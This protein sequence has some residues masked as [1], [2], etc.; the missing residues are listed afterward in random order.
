M[1]D[2][3][4]LRDYLKRATADLSRTKRLLRD[5]EARQ[6]EPIAIVAMSCRY[7][8]GVSSPEDLWELVASGGDAVSSF[9]VNRGWDVS[10]L[11]DPE[12]GAPGKTYTTM[13]GFLHDAG[14]FDADFFKISP[15][16][17]RETDP[18]QRL[19]LET[20]WELFERAGID[21]ASLRGS[22]TGVFTGIVYHDYAPGGGA[23]GLASVASGRIAYSFGL[24]G[25]AV[26]VDTACS[27][28]LVALHWAIQALR[29]GECTL[30]VVGGAT[31]MAGPDSFVGFSQER[32]LAA[33]GRC[34]SFAAAADG[35]AWGEGVGLLLVER[36][37]DAERN[38]HPILAVVR[39]SAVNS[40]GASNGLTAPNGP[41]QQR[42]IQQALASAQLSA[43]DVDVVEGHGTG[44][45]LGDPIEAQAII[46]TYGRNRPAGRP[47]W[48]GSLKSN[49][50]HTQAAAGV[51]GIIK[52]VMALR[53]G[54]LPK[55]LHV[56]EPSPNVDWSAG[57]V[58]LLTEPVP[59]SASGRP[60][61]AGIS[62]F[63]L[64]GTNAHVI[65]E[66]PPTAE[67]DPQV[68]SRPPASTVPV[69]P[70]LLS[71]HTGAALPAQAVRLLTHLDSRPEL[72]LPDI[73]FTSATARA[74]LPHRAV[75]VAA[76]RE[77][78][79]RGLTALVYGT[80]GPDVLR[81][82]AQ[83]RGGTAFLFTG[84]GAQ[85]PGMGQELHAAFPAFA[86]AFDEVAAELDVHLARPL[87]EVLWSDD[88][89]AI[90]QTLYTQAGLFAIEV[91]LFR[92]LEAWGLRPDYLAGHSVGE[93]AAAHAAGVLSVADAAELVAA[94]GR[95]MQ[96]LPDG[97]A[98]ISVQASEEE[99]APLLDDR[100]GL[101]AINGPSA[102]VI[103]GVDAAVSEL[104]A[105]FE[106]KGRK[107]R[108]LRVS[109]AFHS[110][111]MEPMLAEL[112]T[113]AQGLT[114]HPPR[115]PLVSTV[116]G[117]PV[118][119]AELANADYWLRNAR[120]TV[121]FHEAVRWLADGGVTT[122]LELGPAAVLTALAADG[123]P[124][125]DRAY[126]P[127]LR[128]S[129]RSAG[130]A[131]DVVSA[132]GTLHVRGRAIDWRA[133]YEG[134]GGT[135]TE[136]P[137]YAFQRKQYWRE[138]P[139]LPDADLDA[140]RYKI[141]WHEVPAGAPALTGAW[142]VAVPGGEIGDGA[143]EAVATLTAGI[144]GR[145]ATVEVLETGADRAATADAVRR[146]LAGGTPLAGVL[147]LLAFDERPHPRHDALPA[148]TA[149]TLTL[150]QALG[151]AG[152][153]APV[154]C[155]TRRGVGTGPSDAPPSPDQ[156]TIWG[157]GV[158]VAL[159]HPERWGGMV[160]LPETID[161]AALD[162]LAA[163][164]S[165]TTGEDQVAV[166]S[167][168][169]L[170]R[171]MVPAGL[172]GTAPARSWRP[173]G[174]ILITGG[175]GGLGAHVA[176]WLAGRGAEHIVLAGRRGA[177]TPGAAELA[178]ELTA[179]GT[180][181]SVVACDVAQR[182]AVRDLLENLP[183]EPPLTAVVHAAGV[184][185]R[186]ASPADLD[187]DEFAE[188]G[189]AKVAGARH[190]DELLAD[191]P[192]DAFVLFSSGAAIWGSGGQT[193]YASAN[194]Y[195][196][197]LARDR[198]A[199]G[200]TATSI[201]WGPWESGMVDAELGAVL[202][203]IGTPAMRPERAVKALGQ[204]LDHDD[205]EVV[206]ADFD[207]PRFVPAYTL[208]RPRPLLNAL[209]PA[210]ADAG[211]G[212]GPG[213]GLASQPAGPSPALSGLREMGPAEQQRTLL[214][215]VRTQVAAV[216]GYGDATEV[217]PG[218]SFEDMGFD[219]VA[220]V[221]L[222]T[223]LNTATGE[224][225][226]ST[227]V[228]DHP[229]PKALAEHLRATLCAPEEPSADVVL[230]D[231]NRIGAQAGALPPEERAR[232]ASQLQALLDGLTSA[233]EGATT[234]ERLAT[235]SADDLFAFIDSELMTE[236]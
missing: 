19:L 200:L 54:V 9:P 209:P 93:L 55:T 48:L 141:D 111:L 181:V 53:H 43:Q 36:L 218:R 66:E 176:R 178:E 114:Y 156:A 144:A 120:Q 91:A 167:G 109:H 201:A 214:D 166:R 157:L 188:V 128:G 116:T 235:A 3:D 97:G 193:A 133:F 71:A 75:L 83:P 95:L 185:Q 148:G 18:Q 198:R 131:H 199:R 204:A 21:A 220:A 65:I 165:G 172:G 183:A 154:W 225:L 196:D 175:T 87:R 151:D 12:P 212:S 2:V 173:R 161:E 61:R 45:T 127:L 117:G 15:R 140:W 41:S 94:R 105:R 89:G 98:M 49:I 101:A 205:T 32:G 79:R 70:V 123:A 208:A 125:E 47:L 142:L 102:V 132:L 159:D 230:A 191:R 206:I 226:P 187:V 112:R 234:A 28:S 177:A 184:L 24:E 233:P 99:I 190:L 73:G 63:G 186:I 85:R 52:M 143:R 153:T 103:S 27:S 121:R 72:S 231:L 118:G 13:G 227:L 160:D 84:Q 145:G 80:D 202:R 100:V 149:A 67:E 217:E 138:T 155:V 135:R 68:F 124:G 77:D 224:N 182:D 139:A 26:T 195:L 56:D 126:V 58:R 108:R 74:A 88:T 210:G 16:E 162:G 194:A 169:I 164:L 236:H 106:A 78:L 20:T 1:I 51:A 5:M 39:G 221:E 119:A 44:T 33:D 152:V 4:K 8:G 86:E 228:F 113:V 174:T 163:V 37:V 69:L 46:A 11:Y 215:L 229:S 22:R 60:R 31:V 232:V 110:P 129:S 158:G 57:A 42:L 115:V 96:A 90:D 180:R 211:A 104:A 107:I 23:G 136:L 219:S 189:E 207:W 34:K 147:S 92:L 17:A 64:S 122:F 81:G 25:P 82:V 197:A 134:T 59:W 62:S 203:R 222:R 192:L 35:T 130:E 14:Q 170:G 40:D 7:P 223:R 76:D 150:V 216:L 30:A 146:A 137:T 29:A 10:G 179:R 6:G 38:G 50:A 168:R 171:R 213:S